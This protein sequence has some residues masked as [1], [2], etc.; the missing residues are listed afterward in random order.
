[1]INKDYRKYYKLRSDVRQLAH[2]IEQQYCACTKPYIDRGLIDPN[3]W[4]HEIAQHILDWETN[5]DSNQPDR[6]A[7]SI[8]LPATKNAP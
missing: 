3:C 8:R 7:G 4:S 6:E 5:Y 1:M 2:R